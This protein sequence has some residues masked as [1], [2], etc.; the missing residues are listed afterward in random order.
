MAKAWLALVDQER[1]L[2]RARDLYQGRAFSL[3]KWAAEAIKGDLGVI[4]AGLG[5]VLG[6]TSIPSYDLTVRPSGP[7]SVVARIDGI[8]DPRAWWRSI[9]RGPYSADLSSD[10]ARRSLVL[11]CL[12]RTYA[13]MIADDLVEI[14]ASAPSSLRIFG[15][16]VGGALPQTLRRFVL[17]Y[18]ERLSHIGRRGTRV[19]FPQRALADYVEHVAP[20][21][22]ADLDE[23][24]EFIE[25]RLSKGHLPVARQQRRADD[26]TIKRLI[27][28]LLPSVGPSSARMLAHIRHHEGLSCEQRR[29]TALFKQACGR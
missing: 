21:C 23:E 2:I 20:V 16:S 27:L 8:F 10:S 1:T 17:P 29:F 24:R 9:A 18:D 14:T 12:S 11:V 22:G 26:A 15:L 13:A 19:D 25:R 4:S 5:Y 28:E 3:A 7:G 6:D